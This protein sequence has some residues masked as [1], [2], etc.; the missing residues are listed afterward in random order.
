[1]KLEKIE[2]EFN[3]IIFGASG[4]LAKLKLFPSLY[5]LAIQKRFA[6]KFTIY[7]YARSKNIE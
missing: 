1:M 5:E 7:G 2:K 3:F 4:D 6:K